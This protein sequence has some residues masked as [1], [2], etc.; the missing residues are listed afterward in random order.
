MLVVR[1][2]LKQENTRIFAKCFLAR[3]DKYGLIVA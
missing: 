2:L 3:V 1:L